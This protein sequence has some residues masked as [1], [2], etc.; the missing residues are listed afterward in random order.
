MAGEVIMQSSKS[1]GHCIGQAGFLLHNN[2]TNRQKTE[3]MQIICMS[4]ILC[5]YNN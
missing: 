2:Q 4:I 3:P 5:Y 1:C